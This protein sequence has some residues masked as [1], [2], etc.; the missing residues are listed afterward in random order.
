MTSRLIG[1]HAASASCSLSDDNTTD[2]PQLG[3]FAVAL[4]GHQ[5]PATEPKL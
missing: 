5:D 2:P 4:D 3:I 1:L